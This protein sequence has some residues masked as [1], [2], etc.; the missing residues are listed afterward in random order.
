MASGVAVPSNAW[1]MKAPMTPPPM[2]WVKPS[3][4]E[5]VPA[6]W[7]SGSIAIALKFDAI[8]PNWNIAAP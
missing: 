5:A 8:R 1:P 7:P 2:V 4:E 6:T 3:T